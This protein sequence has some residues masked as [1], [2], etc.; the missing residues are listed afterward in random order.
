[1]W[2][3]QG[4]LPTKSTLVVPVLFTVKGNVER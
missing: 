2:L 1:L 4:G 3:G